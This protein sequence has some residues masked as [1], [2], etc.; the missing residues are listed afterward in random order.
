[1]TWYRRIISIE[2]SVL[3]HLINFLGMKHI[4]AR[5]IRAAIKHVLMAS[6][7]HNLKRL[8]KT[9]IKKP[10][11]TAQTANISLNNA[12]NWLC[13]YFFTHRHSIL[14]YIVACNKIGPF[15]IILKN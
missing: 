10:K 14:H 1:M 5:G 6:M 2:G 12:K 11:I 15:H 7:C 8:M 3:G 13:F 4:Q 9:I